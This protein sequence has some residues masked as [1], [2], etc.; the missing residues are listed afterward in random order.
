MQQIVFKR[1]FSILFETVKTENVQHLEKK[2][3]PIKNIV[4]EKIQKKIVSNLNFNK[5]RLIFE[6][7]LFKVS[8]LHL[9]TKF[10]INRTSC[11]DL[12]FY[13]DRQIQRQTLCFI[14]I[15]SRR[16]NDGKHY[17]SIKQ[18]SIHEQLQ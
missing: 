15:T 7:N 5:S 11:L 13:T 14:I 17:L 1:G 16:I 8:L 10:G 3:Q 18:C 9:H 2:I 6:K 12:S 4:I